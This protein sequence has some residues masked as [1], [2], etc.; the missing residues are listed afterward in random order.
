MMS[1][2]TLGISTVSYTHLHIALVG[3]KETDTTVKITADTISVTQWQDVEK[4]DETKP[5]DY[6]EITQTPYT[7]SLIHI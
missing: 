6:K 3:T 2:L 1:V 5:A 7:L 4:V